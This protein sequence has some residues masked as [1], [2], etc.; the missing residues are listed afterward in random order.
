MVSGSA[1]GSEFERMIAKKLSLWFTDGEDHKQLIR[2]VLSG[3]WEKGNDIWQCGDLAPNGPAGT[4]FREH[5][6]VECKHRK[7]I[8]FW[9]M[10]FSNKQGIADAGE[11]IGWWRK[12][13]DEC[14]PFNLCPLLIM[15]QNG[16]PVLVGLPSTYVGPLDPETEPPTMAEYR[17]IL[18]HPT[19]P[20]DMAVMTLDTFLSLSPNA[21]Y[22]HLNDI[23][24]W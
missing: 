9:Q 12:L 23:G 3:G 20:V 4:L 5:F 7:L 13:C 24:Q 11:W 6:A 14:I 18:R 10:F 17:M 8:D 1:K 16:K 21:W 19:W 22:R 15:R 2:S